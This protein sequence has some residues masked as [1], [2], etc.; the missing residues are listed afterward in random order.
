VR[1]FERA[2]AEKHPTTNRHELTL[3]KKKRTTNPTDWE[4]VA[5][6]TWF[7]SLAVASRPLQRRPRRNNLLFRRE[8][9]ECHEDILIRK[10]RTEEM[11]T[12]SEASSAPALLGATFYL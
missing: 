6:A 10:R 5:A 11:D 12:G 9:H 1:G 7:E 8:A 4:A 2:D 3:T